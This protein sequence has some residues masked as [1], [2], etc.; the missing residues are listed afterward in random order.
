[1]LDAT[2]DPETDAA[3]ITLADGEIV[4]TAEVSP[5][6]RFDYDREGRVL[7]IE[8]STASRLL[9]PGEWGS[10]DIVGAERSRASTAPRISPRERANWMAE[11]QAASRR[12]RDDPREQAFLDEIEAIQAE[13]AAIL[14]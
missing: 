8:V 1:M 6:F 10:A 2:Y 13:N 4:K 3:Y 5:G 14:R 11:A 7:G 12:L 9:A